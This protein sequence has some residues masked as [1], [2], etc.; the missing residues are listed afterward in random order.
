MPAPPRRIVSL[1]PSATEL[2]YALG[3]EERLVGVR[4]SAITRPRRA[5]KPNVGGMV[6]PSLETIAVLKPDLVIA[7]T[8]GT[9]HDTFTKLPPIGIPVYAVH[10]HRIAEMIDVARALGE[11]RG[12]Q[13]AVAPFVARPRAADRRA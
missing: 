6:S 13:A 2:I 7:T 4:T 9:R 12:R 11:L 3:G 1:V 10:A 8:S 5:G